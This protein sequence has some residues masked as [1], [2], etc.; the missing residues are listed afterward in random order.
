MAEK[1]MTDYTYANNKKGPFSPHK[2]STYNHECP[3]C[4]TPTWCCEN[5]YMT[6]CVG[7]SMLDYRGKIVGVL[8]L[9]GNVFCEE[10]YP[11]KE[12]ML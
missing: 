9:K 12:N 1:S 2:G 4:G 6:I 11:D 5:P 3:T 8:D 10:C 7:H